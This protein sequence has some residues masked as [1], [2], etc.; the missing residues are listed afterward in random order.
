MW[1]HKNRLNEEIRQDYY[2]ENGQVS[3]PPS[4]FCVNIKIPNY[5]IIRRSSSSILCTS[6]V[7][8]SLLFIT[9]L[10]LECFFFVFF[11]PKSIACACCASFEFQ[12][13]VSAELFVEKKKKLKCYEF[14]H[15]KIIM[16][17]HES[18][19]HNIFW[20]RGRHNRGYGANLAS[21]IIWHIICFWKSWSVLGHLGVIQLWEK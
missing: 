19:L 1:W 5:K 20:G 7:C 12:R 2:W 18:R 8:E 10:F 4:G 3:K 14:I 16:H 9:V 11:S 13:V 15:P 6:W 21:D 17:I